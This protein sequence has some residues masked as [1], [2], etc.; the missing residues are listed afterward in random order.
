ML[1]P[2][3]IK[4]SK[5]IREFLKN[6]GNVSLSEKS[7]PEGFSVDDD[8]YEDHNVFLFYRN[9]KIAVFNATKVMAETIDDKI[10][11]FQ[12]KRRNRHKNR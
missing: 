9:K 3:Q 12:K 5:K 2:S 7:Y 11:E 10:K 8:G 1:K 6:S 4:K